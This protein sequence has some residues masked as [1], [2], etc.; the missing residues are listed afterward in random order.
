MHKEEIQY[1]ISS[2]YARFGAQ[3]AERSFL[4]ETYPNS[5]NG[6]RDNS[7][8]GYWQDYGMMIYSPWQR[9][10]PS[11]D[12]L[13]VYGQGYPWYSPYQFAG[14]KP[15]WA[16]DL[17]GLEELEVTGKNSYKISANYSVD[18]LILKT[19]SIE[20]VESVINQV[21]NLSLKHNLKMMGIEIPSDKNTKSIQFNI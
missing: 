16:V 9:R 5:F 3:L 17:D 13:I 14:N 19:F 12:T 4:S 7:E 18:P 1:C 8:H 21:L 20:V 11:P 6:K 15:I 2:D 10:I